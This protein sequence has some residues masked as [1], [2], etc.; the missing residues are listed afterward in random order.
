MWVFLHLH[1]LQH[2]LYK[3]FMRFLWLFFVGR[4][5]YALFP[6]DS[7]LRYSLF[8][9]VYVEMFFWKLYVEM[10]ICMIVTISITVT[11]SKL[12]PLFYSF[13]T[14]LLFFIPH[15]CSQRDRSILSIGSYILH[16]YSIFCGFCFSLTK[17]NWMQIW[18]RWICHW[19]WKS[20]LGTDPF[21]CYINSSCCFGEKAIKRFKLWLIQFYK[22]NF[23]Y[24]L[25]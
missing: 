11:I 22:I 16:F 3:N 18:Y 19:I 17:H 12:N 9:F 24:F 25:E 20:R 5:V 6:T 8:S 21:G 1:L 7:K 2:H 10:F 23:W 13:S 14:I 15:L 4:S